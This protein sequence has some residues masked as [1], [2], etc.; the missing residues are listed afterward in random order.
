MKVTL[1]V[2]CTPEEARAFFG[3]PDLGPMNEALVAELTQRMRHAMGAMDPETLL[4]TW[5]PA[6]LQGFEQMQK[7]WGQMAAGLGT[8]QG[9]S[10]SKGK[11]K[12]ER[13]P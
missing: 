5:M 3:L 6:T 1:D 13:E 2:D 7:F 8:P 9:P 11:G 12:G 4:A 10:P